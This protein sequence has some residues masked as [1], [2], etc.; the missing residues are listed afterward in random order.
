MWYTYPMKQNP[1]GS[2][3]RERRERLRATDPRGSVRQ[4]AERIG[5]EPSYLSKVERGLVAP[6]SE[7]KILRLAQE[8]GEDPDVL[9]ALAGKVSQELQAAIRKRPALFGEVIRHL[10]DL[11][12]QPFCDSSGKSG[13]GNGEQEVYPMLT[14]EHDRLVV[15]FPELHPAATLQVDFQRTLRIPDDGQDYPLPRGPES[16]PLRHVD[17]YARTVPAPWLEHGGVLLPNVPGGGALGHFTGGG[18]DGWSPYPFAVR[19][20][21][22]K[23]NAVTGAPWQA[24]LR[25]DPQNYLVTPEQPWLDGYCVERGFVRQFVAMPLGTGIAWKSR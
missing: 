3:I 7:A 19:V 17:D 12:D 22:G 2:Y 10:R 8:L 16:F 20:A 5:V 21:T 23:I 4:V 15:A 13:T 6:P 1:F 25:R 24:G 18:D 14:L 9:L 11:P